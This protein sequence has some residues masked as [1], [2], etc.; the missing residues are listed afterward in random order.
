M[1]S[2]HGGTSWANVKK[3]QYLKH[4]LFPQ[5]LTSTDCC[6]NRLT[7]NITVSASGISLK[8][9]SAEASYLAP[10]KPPGMQLKPKNK[11]DSKLPFSPRQKSQKPA[12]SLS[13]TTD[14]DYNEV[15]W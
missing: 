8:R 12:Q 14:S 6:A 5:M 2:D 15:K 9:G 11:I 1:E 13:I 4:F 10:I 7:Q 3:V